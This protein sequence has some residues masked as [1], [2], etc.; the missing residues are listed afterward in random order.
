MNG[1]Q[2]ITSPSREEVIYRIRLYIKVPSQTI[3]SMKAFTLLRLR[4]VFPLRGSETVAITPLARYSSRTRTCDP[5]LKRTW[6]TQIGISIRHFVIAGISAGS[7][8]WTPSGASWLTTTRELALL[9]KPQ[10]AGRSIWT[11]QAALETIWHT[12]VPARTLETLT[13][14]DLYSGECEY[15][16]HKKHR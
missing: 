12:F 15:N 11:D 16:L 13:Q 8:S 6:S 9:R 3:A 2:T 4:V 14:A 5:F 10:I 7:V 1:Q